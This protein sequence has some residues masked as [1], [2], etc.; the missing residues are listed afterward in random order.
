MQPSLPCTSCIHYYITYTF[1]T[2]VPGASWRLHAWFQHDHLT[3]ALLLLL[4]FSTLCLPP[5]AFS[6]SYHLLHHAHC[7][8]AWRMGRP[9]GVLLLLRLGW[10]L[11]CLLLPACQGGERAEEEGCVGSLKKRGEE[12]RVRLFARG[13]SLGRQRKKE[14]EEEK[15]T[16]GGVMCAAA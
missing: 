2:I 8:W 6:I 5:Y 13:G 11:L 14:A 16:R 3:W 1:T 4:L 7:L 15:G 12:D 9:H 10:T